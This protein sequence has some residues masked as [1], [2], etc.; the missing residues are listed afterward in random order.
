MAVTVT[1]TTIGTGTAQPAHFLN[2]EL[3]WL[4]FNARVLHEAFDAR[5]PL[6]ERL[7]FVA[8]F[9]SNLDE[10][11]TVRVAGLRRQVAAGISVP[12]PDGLSPSEQ[13]A[14]I[15]TRVND[16]LAQRRKLLHEL[17]LPALAERSVRLVS[18]A[19]L[20]PAEWLTVDEFFESQVFPV[21]TPL[22]VDPG[23]PF[24][25]ISNLS[26][27]LAV[28]IRDPVKGADHFARVKVPKSLPRWVPF[29]RPNH[30]I[31]LEQVI[32]ANLGALF[33]GMEI[34]GWHAFRV[35]RYSD[36]DLAATDESEDLLEMVEQQV[37]ER[38]FSE[39]V[40]LEVQNTMPQHLRSLL[41]EEL[42][43]EQT[44]ELP[45][46]TEHDVQD[47]GSLLD[48]G[49]LMSLATLDIPEL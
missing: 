16:L 7:K 35:T 31:P 1:D 36:L 10:F 8:I 42:R 12:S 47:A 34:L 41:L 22:A 38:R 48:L 6:F 39:V 9:S 3:S 17:L 43:D 20:T 14:A 28:E 23:H 30:F 27:S 32:G 25:Y 26:L 18:M 33:P 24:P 19:D 37:F 44:A 29:G 21:L 15:T 4:E 5:N 49:D 11:Y 40:R 46:L 13:L 2:R 45:A